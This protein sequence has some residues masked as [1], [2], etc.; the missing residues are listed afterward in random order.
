MVTMEMALRE[1]QVTLALPQVT[2]ALPQ[3]TPQEKLALVLETEL[4]PEKVM[5]KL[6]PQEKLPQE[7]LP[8]EKLPL[9]PLALREK[10]PG[11]PPQET[12]LLRETQTDH[13]PMRRRPPPHLVT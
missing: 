3:V 5:V 9:P 4:P 7:K 13:L 1:T 11:K 2:L 6:L 8:Q 10:P 12:H